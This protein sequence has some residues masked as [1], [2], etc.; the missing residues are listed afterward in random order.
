VDFEGFLNELRTAG[1]YADRLV[2]VR[3]VP[4]RDA[5]FAETSDPLPE[6]LERVLG[7]RGIECLYSHQA[8][9][10]DL[11]RAGKDVLITTGTASGKSLCY[12]LPVLEMLLQNRQSRALLAF[13]TKALCQDQFK[14]FRRALDAAGL[15]D[16]PAG[17]YDGDTPSSTRRRL[18]ESA[19]V[20]FTNPDMLH[21]SIM[22]HHGRWADFLGSLRYLVLDEIHVYNGI[23]GSNMANLMRRFWRV[24]RHYRSA[25]K[26]LPQVIACSATVAN[27]AELAR[28]LTRREVTVVDDD[29]APRGRRVFA[30]W[31][32]PRV[33]G[34]TRR[35]RRSANVEAHELMAKL[36]QSDVPTITFSKARITAEM[37]YRYV[38][39]TLDEEAPHLKKKISP[40]RGG[41]QPG[42]RREIEE[43]LFSGE[44]LGVSTTPALELGI[45]VGGL[46]ASILVGYPG[47][48]ASFF[49]QAGRAGR[50]D[51][52]SLVV[53]VGLDTAINQYIMS[54]P[55]YLFGRPVEEAVIERE[56]PFVLLGHLRCAAHELPLE[57]KEAEEFGPRADLALD[58]LEENQKLRRVDRKWYHSA[59]ETPQ[60]ELS[61]RY[62]YGENVLIED[63]ESG[64]V[65]EEVDKLDAPPLVHPHAI[66]LRHGETWRVLD[67]DMDRNIA[68][69]KRVDVDYYTQALG[70][71][72]VHHI[73]H[74]LR[75]KPFGTG[76]ACWGEVTAYDITWG[77]E[78]IH[79]YTLDAI[80]THGV[81]LPR[82]ALD[83]MAFWIVPPE[84]VMEQVRQRGLNVHSGL[85]GIGYATRM[86]LPLFITCDTLD[87][88][89]TIGSINSPWNAIFVY[90]RYPHGMGFTRKA[91]DRLHEIL[92][93][94]LRQ[95][96]T[97]DCEDG[98]PCCV[99]KPL[100]KFDTWNVE[101]GEGTVPNK[102]AA[103]R[104]LEGLLETGAPLQCPDTDSASDLTEADRQ[105][106]RRALRRRLER[107]R[108]PKVFHPIDPDVQ[109]EY[110]EPEPEEQLDQPDVGM[111]RQRK[112]EFHKELDRR[113]ARKI[114]DHRLGPTSGKPGAP[115]KM[116]RGRGDRSASH[117]PGRP[118]IREVR[119]AP[120]APLLPQPAETETPGAEPETERAEAIQGGD[121][122]AARARRRLRRSAEKND[123]TA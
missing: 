90:E 38:C 79:F 44:L 10:V 54:R 101:R 7:E 46:D 123:E 68:R 12:V 66:Y 116:K 105:R 107:G 65:I 118:A 37:I 60:H 84:Q 45:D 62:V 85:R 113:V 2:H 42:E 16:V 4:P 114:P 87:F 36:V 121:P 61:M 97:C 67:L 59:T 43:R 77:Y 100:R 52:D 106:L 48:L 51:R 76:T 92:P 27:P 112:R 20:I 69:V 95:I 82:L 26:R 6:A 8:R 32:P 58:V 120:E 14:N 18:R 104:I 96:R 81:D 98:C 30:F 55:D 9:A 122:L 72:D 17:V 28:R 63:V 1:G 49:Q 25:G 110:P 74:R 73:D 5:R 31:N 21:A 102:E 71:S 33:R 47:T 15:D 119:D 83:T 19:S 41:Y 11:V 64:E 70:G 3:V 88:S 22:P 39:E 29:G 86:L 115:E 75:R 53:L 108:E 89:H 23:F 56:N 117:F 91:Y 109:T 93:A 24:C 35:S 99:G 50:Q 103:R 94:V 57:E 40:Y 13:P 78:K 111:R 34:T 80:S